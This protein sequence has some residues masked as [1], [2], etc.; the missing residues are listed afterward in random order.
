[1]VSDVIADLPPFK[2]FLANFLEKAFFVHDDR[3]EFFVIGRKNGL[4][5][6]KEKIQQFAIEIQLSVNAII[7]RIQ[8]SFHSI[9]RENRSIANRFDD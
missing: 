5:L 7:E 9:L 3:V 8:Q 6:E 1:V 2:F 4:S